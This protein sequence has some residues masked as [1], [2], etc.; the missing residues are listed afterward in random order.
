MPHYKDANNKLYFLDSDKFSNVL[1]IGCVQ[2]TDAEAQTL[3]IAN[4]PP[5]TE[6]QIEKET[7]DY[8]YAL[9]DALAQSWQYT[10][11]A[12]ARTYRGDVNPKYAA[13]ALA[14]C[15]YGSGCFTVLDSIKAGTT[16]RPENMAALLALLPATPVRP[17]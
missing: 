16:A 8:V 2:I 13:E 15:N 14:I 1:P 17:S 10:S 4:T 12:S 3:Q 11:Y 6:A 5:P 7:G 9:C